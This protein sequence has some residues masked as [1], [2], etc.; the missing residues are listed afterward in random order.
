MHRRHLIV[1]LTA[2]LSA[3]A[4]WH[5][6]EP[7][8]SA[9]HRITRVAVSKTGRWMAAASASGWVGVWER[10][11]PESMGR[12]RT[13]Q[14]KV[15]DLAFSADERWL[16]IESAGRLWRQSV[17]QLG[18]LEPLPIHQQSQF[19]FGANS[20][21]PPASAAA[22]SNTIA[23]PDPNTVLFGNYAGSVEI[24]STETKRVLQRFTFR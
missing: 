1:I 6:S 11:A 3:A 21:R 2:L 23:G 7:S 24:W 8:P 17:G 12:F 20:M 15:D 16:G 13:A 19:S 14:G 10:S 22:T 9:D 4:Y 18:T 5:W